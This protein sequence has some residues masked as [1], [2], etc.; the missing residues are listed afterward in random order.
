LS[1]TKPPLVV[2]PLVTVP[3]GA[4]PDSEVFQEAAKKLGVSPKDLEKVV[5]FSDI[6][7]REAERLKLDPPHVVSSCLNLVG[8]LLNQYV[9]NQYKADMVTS[10]FRQLW[11]HAG[12]PSDHPEQLKKET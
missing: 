5:E 10:I 8:D 4:S 2:S 6:L 7:R 11:A 3:V 1:K 9:D 12:L